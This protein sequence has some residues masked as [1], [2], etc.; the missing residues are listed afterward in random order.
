MLMEADP[1]HAQAVMRSSFQLAV[2]TNPPT[3]EELT[4]LIEI[5]PRDIYQ[6]VLMNLVTR[7][8]PDYQGQILEMEISQYDLQKAYGSIA[9]KGIHGVLYE[10][11]LAASVVS[12]LGIALNLMR[13]VRRE[14][15]GQQEEISRLK[16]MLEGS[17]EMYLK[18][19]SELSRD[20]QRKS[21]SP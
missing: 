11:T 10:D 9:G 17:Q 1:E 5:M 2:A 12:G 7:R 6:F 14:Q 4:G 8:H 18:K 16:M 3:G 20:V 19:M 15:V 21:V 13:G